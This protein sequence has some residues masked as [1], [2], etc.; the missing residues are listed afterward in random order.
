MA[1]LLRLA[2]SPPVRSAAARSGLLGLLILTGL[3]LAA[4]GPWLTR[5]PASPALAVIVDCSSSMG[6]ADG[7]GGERRIDGAGREALSLLRAAD[8]R[9]TRL[10][11]LAGAGGSVVSAGPGET[12]LFEEALE[13]APLVDGEPPLDTL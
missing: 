8:G 13:G 5:G 2:A 4:A 6:T 1:R 10:L 9:P 7:P 3:A 12:R 11:V